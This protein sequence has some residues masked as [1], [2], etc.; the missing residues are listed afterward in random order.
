MCSHEFLV[1]DAEAGKDVL[2]NLL[3]VEHGYV[4]RSLSPVAVVSLAGEPDAQFGV[5]AELGKHAFAGIGSSIVVIAVA[6]LIHL[7]V[8]AAAIHIVS[9]AFKTAKEQ[10]LTHEHEVA[11]ERVHQ[12]HCAGFG[13]SFALGIIL[14]RCE[15]VV[16][17]FVEAHGSE[18]LRNELH[19]VVLEI[20]SR[21]RRQVAAHGVGEFHIVV[22]I[23]TKD[24]LN[25]VARALH[26]DAIGGHNYVER[27][28]GFAHN[29]HFEAF[30]NALDGV[31][32][33]AFAN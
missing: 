14:H 27:L 12:L 24:V 28:V 7:E 30:E 29:L 21:L 25:H 32:A 15:R 22:A 1:E 2:N 10:C 18:L 33:D 23:H 9:N 31:L 5:F 8:A 16:Q 19:H 11:A 4:A 13:I 26:V 17:Y 6:E 3:E 20:G